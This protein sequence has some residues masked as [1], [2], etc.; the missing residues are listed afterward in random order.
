MKRRVVGI[1]VSIVLALAGTVLL[2]LYVNHAKDNAVKADALEKVLVV[3]KTIRQGAPID[4][5]AKN[6]SLAEVPTKLVAADSVKVLSGLD[7][8]LVA[9]VEL[10]KGEQLLSTRL[11]DSR[12]LTRT[13]VPAGLQEITISLSPERAVG[14]NLHAGDTVG[15]LF[16]FQPFDAASSG[17]PEATTDPAATVTRTPNTTHFT[18]HRILV[19]A[20][21]FS[22]QDS[23]RA[24]AIQ[25]TPTDANTTDTTIAATVAQSPADKALVTL[26]VTAPEAEQ[27]VFAAEF[28]TIWLTSENANAKPDG[29]R[30]VTLAQVYVP[31]PR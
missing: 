21:Q 12:T 11:V 23:E 6:V 7:S 16:S 19:T 1:V 3:D 24:G 8:S 22:K 18:L 9:G 25:G 31:V 27:L 2:V 29:T 17:T 4:E 20:I 13:E 30:I 15:V 26:A 14:A 10:K 28:G 5:I